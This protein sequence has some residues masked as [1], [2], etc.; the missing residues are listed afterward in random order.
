V[1]RYLIGAAVALCLAGSISATAQEFN[2]EEQVLLCSG[3]H[4]EKGMPQEKTTPIIWGQHAGYLYLQLK[5]F[6][7]GDRK[8]EQMN[9]IAEPYV[10]K[11]M[12]QL[13]EH[14]AK[15]PWPRSDAKAAPD[16]V[17]LVAARANVAVGCTGCHQEGYK[18]EG[19]QARLA[20]QTREYLQKTM[21][22][23][24]NSD[25]ANNAGMT[26]LMKATSESDITA[27]A[28]FLAG[29]KLSQ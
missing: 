23:I 16:D 11:D 26:T 4:G 20:G 27:M 29:L 14:F 22:D 15:Q 13:A 8:H 9:I 2:L 6:K 19:T 24:R 7:S 21:I 1:K 10:R 18:G 17:A 3:C 28:E 25:R 5:D 12:L